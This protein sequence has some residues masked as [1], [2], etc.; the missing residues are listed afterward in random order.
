LSF[1]QAGE[2]RDREDSASGAKPTDASQSAS[3]PLDDVASLYSWANL[4]GVKYRD[5][6]AS[7]QEARAQSQYRLVEVEPVAADEP[8]PG[9]A[10]IPAPAR[11]LEQPTRL[12]PPAGQGRWQEFAEPLRP[13]VPPEPGGVG[14]AISA[15]IPVR[16]A[17]SKLLPVAPLAPSP[18]ESG[19][20]A[21]TPAWT[22]RGVGRGSDRG[23]DLGDDR[24]VDRRGMAYR[25]LTPEPVVA[26]F[27][28]A[29]GAGK[30]S[31]TANL[32]RALSARG[33]PVL[34]VETSAFGTLPFYFGARDLRPGA[35]RTFASNVGDVPIQ[36]LSLDTEQQGKDRPA[37]WLQRELYRASRE[38]S[39]ILIDVSGGFHG[40]IEEV[41]Q[42]N[43]AVVIPV[44]PERSAVA[45][46]Q[47]VDAAFR[48]RQEHQGEPVQ[49]YFLLNQFDPTLPLHQDVRQM[50]ARTFGDR[51]LPLVVHRSPLV[52]EA[53]AEGLTVLDYAPTAPS[54]ED[55]QRL[56]G[57]I[58]GLAPAGATSF[59]GVRWS[60]R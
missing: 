27:S 50:L 16:N 29:G 44:L 12:E 23:A 10:V 33:E 19:P 52:G 54:V 11:I 28:V 51:L 24:G 49:P 8:Q 15:L 37:H 18:E 57:W 17:L 42:L 21:S 14:P 30:T 26:I 4:H 3:H 59:R 46:L 60:E 7:R 53:L 9:T 35:V 25:P 6:S 22:D 5:F 40:I 20:E 47:A 34:A 1:L 55:I 2:M 36:L 31:L 48:T 38:A 45:T 43:P 39:R 56:A 13:A 41:L 32:A 58:R